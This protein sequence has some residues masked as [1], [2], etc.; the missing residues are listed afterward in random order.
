MET[1]K[2]TEMTHKFHNEI[3]KKYI[4]KE[5]I[6]GHIY[7]N[8]EKNPCWIVDD[9]GEEIVLM[10]CEPDIICIL[11]K[12]SYQKIL[13][14]E[15]TER[16]GKKFSWTKK[17]KA[18]STKNYIRANHNKTALYIHQ[19]IMNCYGNGSGTSSI[20]VD[21]ID[22]NPLNNK[23]SNL[24]IATCEEQHANSKGIIP[25]TKKE[26]RNDARELPHN[27]LQAEL[28][29]Y[30]TYTVNKYGENNEFQRE[31]FKIEGHPLLH[32]KTWTSTTKHSVTIEEKLQQAK[33]ALE[34]LN[35]TGKLQEPIERELPQY[36]SY[37]I[38]RGNH[39]L[40]WQRNVGENRLSKKITLTGD[41][42]E[43]NKETQE[44]ELRRLNVEL[45]KKYDNQYCIFELKE[46]DVAKI[47]KV[48]LEELPNYVRFQTFYD[49]LYLV[50][51]K[52]KGEDR[53]STSLKLPT[54][55]NINKELHILNER[56][57]E[58]F[59]KENDISLKDYP[60]KEDDDKV[61]IPEGV[62]ISLKCKNPYIFTKKDGKTY[63]MSLPEKYNLKE[64]IE[65]LPENKTEDPFI[66]IEETKKLFVEHG[67]KPDNISICFKDN[68]YYQLQY[69]LKTKEHRQDKTMGIPKENININ[70]ELIKMNEFIVNKYGK[71]FAILLCK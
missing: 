50:Y 52:N 4:I 16:D 55:Y 43:L 18:N 47:K 6:K 54:N 69:K 11:C 45:I 20:S 68:K 71:E 63:S 67:I 53:I 36:V 27:I 32:D 61:E 30:I 14:F 10:Y 26:R 62:Y 59:G 57:I 8:V 34:M 35:T 7:G 37:Y 9:N 17:D 23:M 24:R 42:F 65:L 19:V 3:A 46:E 60:Y 40:A 39:L 31:Y 41:Y 15:K 66:T 22:R 12:K 64:Q 1:I 51:N 21:H 33:N 29:K 70:L 13:D 28:P 48:K 58:K 44:K 38:E 5:Y 49:G 56:I 25:N 2:Q